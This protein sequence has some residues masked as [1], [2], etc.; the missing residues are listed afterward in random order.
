L[1]R[2]TG[3]P[4]FSFTSEPSEGIAAP[5]TGTILIRTCIRLTGEITI[6]T[7]FPATVIASDAAALAIATG[8][9]LASAFR[10]VIIF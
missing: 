8:T 7:A 5:P 2:A 3:A 4:K 9:R 1:I 6:S 10:R